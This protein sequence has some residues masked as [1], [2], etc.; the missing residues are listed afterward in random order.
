MIPPRRVIAAVDFSE[1]SRTALAFA[2]RLAA[3]SRAELH[4]LHVLDPLLAAA[5]AARGFDLL[6]DTRQEL[7]AFARSSNSTNAILHVITGSAA[8]AVCDIAA[9]ERADVVVIGAHGMSGPEHVVFGSVA[10]GVIRRATMSVLVVPAGWTPP[11]PQRGDLIG[12]GPVI[13]G[14]DLCT[15]S[16]EAAA[17][18]C[19]LAALLHTTVELVH[20]IPE[21]PVLDRWKGHADDAIASRRPVV[22]QQLNVL[23]NAIHAAVPVTTRIETGRLAERLAAVAEPGPDRRPVLVL[24]RRAETS[25]SGAP[26]STAYRVL[27]LA[28]VPVFVHLATDET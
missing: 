24:G 6:R 12:T 11:D 25:R 5:A 3:Q 18:A 16:V 19:D 23:I 10:E 13:A 21:L 8:A 2:S 17:A 27:M 7:E 9:R 14:T 4:L 26:G 15:P 28:R 22:Q 1:P 20:V